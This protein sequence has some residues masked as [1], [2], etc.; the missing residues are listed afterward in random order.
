[1]IMSKF[2]NAYKQEII[3][4]PKETSYKPTNEKFDKEKLYNVYKEIPKSLLK[5]KKDIALLLDFVAVSDCLHRMFDDIYEMLDESFS[6]L[7]LT[8]QDIYKYIIAAINREFKVIKDKRNENIRS[9]EKGTY[10]LTDIMN[11]KMEVADGLGHKIDTRSALEAFTDCAN[12]ILNYLRFY[13]DQSCTSSKANPNEF[14]GRIIAMLR[15]VSLASVFKQTY[16]DILYNNGFVRIDKEHKATTFDYFDYDRLILIRAGDLVFTHQRVRSFSKFHYNKATPQISKLKTNYRIK[17]VEVINGTIKL[18][19]GQGIPK[20]FDSCLIDMQ[21]AIDSFYEFL[22]GKMILDGLDNATIDEAVAVWCTCQYICMYIIENVN[23]DIPLNTKEDFAAVPYQIKKKDLV[24]YIEKLISVK[25][26]KIVA[27]L[28]TL[29]ATLDKFNDIWSAPIYPNGDHYLLPFYPLIMTA[30]FHIFDQLLRKGGCD[31]DARGKWFEKYLYKSLTE[32][33]S[34][35]PIVC[36]PSGKFGLDEQNKEEIDLIV[37]LNNIVILIE[38][39]CI[40]YSMNPIN[41]NEAWERLKNGCEQ[42]RRKADFVKNNPNLFNQLGDYCHKEIVPVVITNYPT[43]TGLCHSN[44]YVTDAHSFLSY[45]FSGMMAT[46][47]LQINIDCPISVQ[48]F[49]RNESEFSSNFKRYIQKNPLKEELKKSIHI[50]N[51]IITT[52][53]KWTYICKYA[54]IN[55]NPIFDI[56]SK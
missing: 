2:F 52:N 18:K 30:P 21:S 26:K 33:K 35:Y 42:A 23:F 28:N 56:H 16:D 8:G 14:A 47:E 4:H 51:N 50:D 12:L 22:D 36:I 3:K 13:R 46:R 6:L 20:E 27:V 15:M 44:V 31:L 49:Y 32:R 11:F 34:P 1:M 9:L 55:N 37:S 41:Y 10:H 19:F 45:I 25:R 39:K 54:I 5:T 24:D 48:Y 17:K 53:S 7:N 38:A 40:H 43:F 29:T